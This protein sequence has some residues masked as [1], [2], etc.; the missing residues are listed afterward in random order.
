MAAFSSAS[1]TTLPVKAYQGPTARGH[2]SWPGLNLLAQG[3]IKP[4][5]QLDHLQDTPYELA[6]AT[7][8][9]PVPEPASEA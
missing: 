9:R 6:D 8:E 7:E 3:D 5:T 1:R 2:P 4:E